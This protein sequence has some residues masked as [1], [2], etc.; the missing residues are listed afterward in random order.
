MRKSVKKFG[1]KFLDRLVSFQYKQPLN[2]VTEPFTVV[3]L[4]PNPSKK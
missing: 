4:D 1:V 3:S 2:L